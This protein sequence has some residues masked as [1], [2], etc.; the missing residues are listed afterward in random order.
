MSEDKIYSVAEI[1]K[2]LQITTQA[3]YGKIN[4]ANFAQYTVAKGGIKHVTKAGMDILLENRRTDKE[5]QVAN[6]LAKIG[7]LTTEL[8]EQQKQ[9]EE[10][11]KKVNELQNR[12]NQQ[13]ETTNAG[14]LKIIDQ[15]QQLQAMQMQAA[16]KKGFWQKLLK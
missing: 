10:L 14:L 5:N 16:E 1:A 7:N 4:K 9:L 3:V 12:L 8:S 6:I 11:Q 13:Q 15:Q 2:E